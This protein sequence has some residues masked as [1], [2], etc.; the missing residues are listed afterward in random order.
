MAI[1]AQLATAKRREKFCRKMFLDIFRVR[2]EAPPV[3]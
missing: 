3:F 2:Q 1:H